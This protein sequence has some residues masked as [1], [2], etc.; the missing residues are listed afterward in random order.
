[1]VVKIIRPGILE[2]GDAFL[3]SLSASAVLGKRQET[4]IWAQEDSILL[5]RLFLE[6]PVQANITPG[7]VA[8]KSHELNDWLMIWTAGRGDVTFDF[9][10]STGGR[11]VSMAR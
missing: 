1:M 4:I 11:S 2:F 9:L 6:V 5:T 7:I 10:L 8:W 3:E